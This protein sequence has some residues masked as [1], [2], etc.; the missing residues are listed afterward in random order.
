MKQQWCFT[1][2]NPN[3]SNN[4]SVKSDSY[5]LITQENTKDNSLQALLHYTSP[6]SQ[7]SSRYFMSDSQL[8]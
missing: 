1:V 8:L 4:T 2:F 5:L 6:M 7:F 3:R